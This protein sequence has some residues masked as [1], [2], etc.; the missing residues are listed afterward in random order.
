MNPTNMFLML[1][2]AVAGAHATVQAAQSPESAKSESGLRFQEGRTPAMK[3]GGGVQGFFREA[4][5][6]DFAA[7]VK[8]LKTG[9]VPQPNTPDSKEDGEGH[10]SIGKGLLL[11]GIGTALISMASFGLAGMAPV[12]PG[13]FNAAL[14]FIG[15]LASWNG[16]N[17]LS[18]GS[19]HSTTRGVL[20]AAAG[21]GAM[22]AAAGL[23]GPIGGLTAAALGI[24][25]FL[26]AARGI[27]KLAGK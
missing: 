24:G 7:E 3:A 9:S 23:F 26:S 27:G 22:A 15:V 25:G 21:V 20:L 17:N 5:R 14:R 11:I 12:A 8:G 13:L 6:G 2:L 16:A 19:K 4:T 10:G 18:Q 1:A